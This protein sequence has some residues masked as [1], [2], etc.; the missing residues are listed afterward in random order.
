MGELRDVKRPACFQWQTGACRSCGLAVSQPCRRREEP[1]ETTDAFRPT[2]GGRGTESGPS[3]SP[4]ARAINPNR[5]TN[6]Q[7]VKRSTPTAR[8]VSSGRKRSTPTRRTNAQRVKRSTPTARPVS[9]GRKRSTP[10]RRTGVQREK[11]LSLQPPDW[12]E[13]E[14][15]W[16]TPSFRSA[17]PAKDQ[18][19]LRFSSIPS[20]ET[21]GE[22]I[23]HRSY[24]CNRDHA[25]RFL[26]SETLEKAK[27]RTHYRQ[28]ETRRRGP[29]T[30][31]SQTAAKSFTKVACKPAALPARLPPQ[32][33]ETQPVQKLPLSDRSP[34]VEERGPSPVG[35]PVAVEP[36]QRPLLGRQR[37]PVVFEQ[38]QLHHLSMIKT[39]IPPVI[40]TYIPPRQ[41]G[42]GPW[43]PWYADYYHRAV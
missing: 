10:T 2:G 8:P 32:Q 16:S 1:V 38:G 12:T 17:L 14:G 26:W 21:G 18:R 43:T 25:P 23:I 30:P 39:Y 41:V 15:P 4:T 11:G 29:A 9:S 3:L 42:D 20:W 7:R 36:P 6:A 33:T 40:T 24:P 35:L 13:D 5:Q 22:R 28:P 19:Q 31:L 37:H 27:Q 34:R